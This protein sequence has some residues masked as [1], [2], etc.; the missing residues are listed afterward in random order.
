MLGKPSVVG[1]EDEEKVVEEGFG[2]L[3]PSPADQ[4]AGQRKPD[5][6]SELL[7]KVM[8]NIRDVKVAQNALKE[9]FGPIWEGV[10]LLKKHDC[11][12]DEDELT[13]LEAAPSKWEEVIR[14]AFD[15]R[16]QILPL[17]NKEIVSIK[18]KLEVFEEE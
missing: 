14:V 11:P 5:E 7:Y 12:I 16:E 4:F 1:E 8:T 3:G 17:Q 10:A 6:N 15:A 13:K 9:M 2:L 18:A